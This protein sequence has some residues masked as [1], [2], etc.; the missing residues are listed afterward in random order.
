MGEGEVSS[1]SCLTVENYYDIQHILWTL[2]SFFLIV[3]YYFG[4]FG[5]YFF[6][7]HRWKKKTFWD[8][9]NSLNSVICPC[10][11]SFISKGIL[12]KREVCKHNVST[13]EKD[14][15]RKVCVLF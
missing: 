3:S 11:H 7:V 12:R 10:M 8:F 9:F 14:E 4:V 15:R 2:I 5:T 6:L 1:A 13:I